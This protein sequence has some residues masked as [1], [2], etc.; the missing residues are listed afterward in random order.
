MALQHFEQ[1]LIAGNFRLRL[2]ELLK[3]HTSWL[4]GGMSGPTFWTPLL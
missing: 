2:N 3:Y 4:V 1:K